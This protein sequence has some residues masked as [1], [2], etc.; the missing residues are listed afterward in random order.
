MR[1]VLM[2]IMERK[3]MRKIKLKDE[4]AM[5]ELYNEINIIV[6]YSGNYIVRI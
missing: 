6:A 4:S 3:K 1:L 2:M 5:N